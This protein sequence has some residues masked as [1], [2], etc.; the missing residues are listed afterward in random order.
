MWDG[1]PSAGWGPPNSHQG[2]QDAGYHLLPE[3]GD[4][5]CVWVWVSL[6]RKAGQA[7]GLA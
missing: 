7:G 6:Q 1:V 5:H 2:P 3:E 4:E